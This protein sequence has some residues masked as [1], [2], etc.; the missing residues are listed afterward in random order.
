VDTE[1]FATFVRGQTH[2]PSLSPTP[3]ESISKPTL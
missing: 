2:G 1:S 3:S